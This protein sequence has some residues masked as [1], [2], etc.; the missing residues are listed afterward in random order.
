MADPMAAR[1]NVV[2]PAHLCLGADLV[3]SASAKNAK[4]FDYGSG[5]NPATLSSE[6][7]I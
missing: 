3:S 1:T 4:N 7:V 5:C 2:D 6:T